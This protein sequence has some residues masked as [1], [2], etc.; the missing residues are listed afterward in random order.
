MGLELDLTKID[1][2]DM[3]IFKNSVARY[4]RDRD[5]WHTGVFHRIHTVDE[6]LMGS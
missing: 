4:K 6:D 2:N 1:D 3:T 5:L